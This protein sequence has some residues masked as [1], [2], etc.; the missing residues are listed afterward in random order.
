MVCFW[1][2]LISSFTTAGPTSR[3]CKK[4]RLKN[5]FVKRK[6][7]HN[8]Q[9]KNNIEDPTFLVWF[10][11]DIMSKTLIPISR[12]SVIISDIRRTDM[13]FIPTLVSICQGPGIWLWSRYRVQL[14]NSFIRYT[15]H[16]EFGPR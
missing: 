6:K 13:G 14:K 1:S 11:L 12:I 3:I 8:L 4:R 15:Y 10:N 9:K 7:K 5:T 2:H 16:I